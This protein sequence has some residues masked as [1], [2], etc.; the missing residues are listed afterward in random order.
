[1]PFVKKVIISYQQIKTSFVWDW[2]IFVWNME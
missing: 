2:C 1:V